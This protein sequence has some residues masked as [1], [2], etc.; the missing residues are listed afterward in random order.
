MKPLRWVFWV[1]CFFY[2]STSA[3]AFNQTEWL[4]L[5]AEGMEVLENIDTVTFPNIVQKFETFISPQNVAILSS[6]AGVCFFA[7]ALMMMFFYQFCIWAIKKRCKS[8]NSRLFELNQP[9]EINEAH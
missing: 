5:A 1:A 4:V 6:I 9:W 7:P 8:A 2:L 3:K